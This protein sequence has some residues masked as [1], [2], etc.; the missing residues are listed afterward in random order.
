MN[1]CPYDRQ[2]GAIMVIVL[3]FIALAVPL[4]T[5]ALGLAST[6]SID[7]RIK[8]RLAKGQYSTIAGNQHAI[9]RIFYESGYTEGLTEGVED[10]YVIDINGEQITVSVLKLSDP[11][12]DPPPP[13]ADSS[14]KFQTVKIVVPASASPNVQT[15]FTYT[16]TVE[17]RDSEPEK[18]NKVHDR[19]EPGF[20]YVAGTTSGVTT[21]DPSIAV[22][23]DGN[24]RLPDQRMGH[25]SLGWE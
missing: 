21:G 23:D 14:R 3:A 24:E 13:D 16:V 22:L 12:N 17:N 7:S 8:T 5:G 1:P 10:N 4:V 11:V 20:A 15:T 19:L 25:H 18:L 6:L 9:Y 2:R